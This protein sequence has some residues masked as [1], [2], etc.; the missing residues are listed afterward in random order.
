MIECNEL[1]GKVIR[2]CNLF[3][4]GSGGPEL[5]I[6]FTDGTSFVAGLKV[7]ISK[8]SICE[9]MAEV[10]NPQGIH[11]ARTPP[12]AVPKGLMAKG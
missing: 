4:D 11:A 6:D 5:Q 2:A 8:R 9:T 1:V 10:E 7:E 12:L 3:E